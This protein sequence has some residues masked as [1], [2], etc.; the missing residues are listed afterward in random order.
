MLDIIE[1]IY[2]FLFILFILLATFFTLKRKKRVAVILASTAILCGYVPIQY[3]LF[4]NLEPTEHTNTSKELCIL[5]Q[6]CWWMNTSFEGIRKEIDTHN[7]DIIFLQEC[8]PEI[9]EELKSFA[10]NKNYKLFWHQEA[11]LSRY[12]VTLTRGMEYLE[13][14]ADKDINFL[15]TIVLYHGKKLSL[16]N[17]HLER[18]YRVDQTYYQQFVNHVR[19]NSDARILAGDFNLVPWSKPFFYILEQL[20]LIDSRK[21]HGLLAT[22]PDRFPLKSPNLPFG[23][24]ILPIDHILISPTSQVKSYHRLNG[25]GSD[26]YGL[27]TKIDIL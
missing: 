18:P 13:H 27:V 15:E 6:N 26:H 8:S 4:S 17:A 20:N 16:I 2:P 5:Q 21:G 9:L 19:Q 1:Q 11:Y 22:F 10:R 23:I 7:P 3:S 12:L 14:N 24:A 25:V